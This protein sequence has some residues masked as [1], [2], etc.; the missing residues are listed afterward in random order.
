[1]S[2]PNF[3]ACFKQVEKWEGWRKFTNDP[4]DPGGSTYSGV[5]QSAYNAWRDLKN[6]PRMGVQHATDE[7]ITDLYRAQYW[8]AVKG[9]DLPVG[10]DCIMFS[11]AVNMGPHTA[12]KFMQSAVG[13]KA[14]GWIGLETLGAVKRIPVKPI[15]RSIAQKRLSYWQR[16]KTWVYYGKGW[17]N[18]GADDLNEALAMVK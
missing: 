1:M 16:L 2:E 13:M 17:S 4:H 6:L 12:I 8:D 5:T 10:L 7:E 18:R 15:I 11:T 3:P 9:D 14:D